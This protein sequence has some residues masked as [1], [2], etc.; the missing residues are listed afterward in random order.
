[1]RPEPPLL[2]LM[3]NPTH[4]ISLRLLGLPRIETLDDFSALTHLSAGFLFRLSHFADKYYR[5]YEIPKRTGGRR[6]IAQPS[7]EM[8]ALQ[9]WILRNILEGLRVSPAAKGFEKGSSIVDNAIPHRGS[10]AVLCLDLEDFF[11]SIKVNQVWSVFHAVGY[12]PA[13]AAILASI[14]C[15]KGGLPQGGPT[16]PKLANLVTLRLDARLL[17]LVGK[18]GIVY[19]R[20]A[21]DLTFSTFSAWKLVGCLPLIRKIIASEGFTVNREKTRLTGP[22]KQHRI[23]G[24]V[25]TDKDV[26]IGRELL[27]KLRSKIISLCRYPAGGAP[28]TDLKS[29]KGWFAYVNGVDPVRYGMMQTYLKR[30]KNK[31][32]STGI[33]DL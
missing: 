19:T 24:L 28:Q 2:A 10:T 21:D 7:R 31:H 32:P 22:G 3:P 30:L 27:R 14:C 23:T 8:K 13:I 1:M 6:V 12:S 25:V 18:R 4:A 15:F 5:T 17:G 26:G 9:S 33:M 20:Y 11:P 16:S 29:I